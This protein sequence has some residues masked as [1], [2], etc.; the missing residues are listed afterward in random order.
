MSEP[1]RIDVS[2]AGEAAS[3]MPYPMTVLLHPDRLVGLLRSRGYFVASPGSGVPEMVEAAREYAK[4]LS[5][6][7]VIDAKDPV[8]A[9]S[10]IDDADR[11][12]KRA[13]A[14]ISEAARKVAG[15]RGE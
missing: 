2:A 4:A 12:L 9:L 11:A 7:E 1:F 14:G 5:S 10:E 13:R 6:Y 3:I 15:E 8:K